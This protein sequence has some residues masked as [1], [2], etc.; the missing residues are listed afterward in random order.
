MGRNAST[1]MTDHVRSHIGSPVVMRRI[2]LDGG[3]VVTLLRVDDAPCGGA[4]TMTTSGLS[5]LGAHRLH[6]ELV[7]ACWSHGPVD[8][9]SYVVEFVARQLAR[10]REPLLYGDVVGPAGPLVPGVKMEA[11][12][13]C[14]PSYFPDGFADYVSHDGCEVRVRWLLPIF[15]SEASVVETRGAQHFETLLEEGDPDLLS[16][17]RPSAVAG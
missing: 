1:S 3:A 14:V 5:E 13:V 10:G 7:M 2:E 9:L 11:L 17:E 4:T 15:P 16:L 12:Y 8:E 6:E